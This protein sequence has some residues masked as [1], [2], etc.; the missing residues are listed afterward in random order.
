VAQDIDDDIQF[1]DSFEDPPAPPFPF[2][3]PPDPAAIAP[4]IDTTV[5]GHFGD[6]LMFLCTAPEP[7]Q[8]G[9]DCAN[10]EPHRVAA[11]R[12]RAF[13][14]NGNP[15][16]GVL[17]HIPDHPEFGYTFSRADGYYDLVVNGGGELTLQFSKDDFLT[18]QR[19][20]RVR[21]QQFESVDDVHLV[22]L[23]SAV[24]E[25]LLGQGFMQV[26]QATMSSDADGDRQATM[27]FPIGLQAEIRLADGSTQALSTMNVRATEYTVG[28]NGPARMPATLPEVT[29]YTYA[30]ELS[31]DEAIALA[32]TRVEFDQPIWLYVE[33]FLDFP[34]GIPVPV[35]YYDFQLQSWIPSQDGQIIQIVDESNGF[36]LVDVDGDGAAEDPID[37]QTNLSMTSDEL[38]Q[39]AVL[40]QPGQSLWRSPIMHFTP[41]D[42]NWPYGPGPDD[43]PPPEPTTD[44]DDDNPPPDTEEDDTP[45]DDD[46]PD[47]EDGS[48]PPDDSEPTSEEGGDTEPESTD[49]EN[50]DCMTGSIIECENRV[51][52]ETLRIPG[53]DFN[54]TYRSSRSRGGNMGISQ[55]IVRV[56]IA[57]GSVPASLR[58]ASV[59][60]AVDGTPISRSI[61]ELSPFQIE[62]FNVP[63]ADRFSREYLIRSAKTDV[64]LTYWYE[65]FYYGNR[66]DFE[67]SFGIT[68]GVEFIGRRGGLELG[69]SRRW[70]TS[71]NFRSGV[72]AAQTYLAKSQKLGGWTL[73]E[74]HVFDARGGKLWKGDGGERSVTNLSDIQIHQ[75][76]P[77]GPDLFGQVND[78]DEIRDFDIGPDGSIVVLT[79]GFIQRLLVIDQDNQIIQI[80]RSCQP[81]FVTIPA[82]ARRGDV[83]FCSVGS[84]KEANRGDDPPPPP[85]PE[86]EWSQGWSVAWGDNGQ[87]FL[88]TQRPFGEADIIRFESDGTRPRRFE[89][90]GLESPACFGR[91]NG[92]DFHNRRLFFTC[93]S[94]FD[95]GSAWMLWPNGS[96]SP[97]A[98]AIIEPPGDTLPGAPVSALWFGLAEP[99]DISVSPDGDIYIAETGQHRIRKIDSDGR[100]STIAGTGTAGF[101]GEGS[102]ATDALLSS[103]SAVA[104]LPDGSLYIADTGNGRLRLVDRAGRISTTAGGGANEFVQSGV[105]GAIQLGLLRKIGMHE[106][107]S[108]VLS[109]HSLT[110]LLQVSFNQFT[111][112]PDADVYTIPSANGSELFIFSRQGRHLETRFTLTYG[113]KYSFQYNASGYLTA[114][115]DGDG[116]TTQIQ[117][118]TNNLAESIISPYGV[119]TSLEYNTNEDLSAVVTADSA[120]WEMA[121]QSNTG[122]LVEFRDPRNN[123]SEYNYSLS[124]DLAS[125]I[126]PAGGGWSVSKWLNRS[127]DEFQ[128]I[129][130]NSNGDTAR[131]YVN[132][133]AT[134]REYRRRS[135]PGSKT[136]EVLTPAF[137]KTVLTP[138]RTS[139]YTIM[140]PDPRFGLLAPITDKEIIKTPFGLERKTER[141]RV[142]TAQ[143]SGA[144]LGELDIID[145][146]T[147]NGRIWQQSYNSN[148]LTWTFTSPQGRVS[149]FSL[150]QQQRPIR[151]SA[152][153]L[154]AIDFSY[155]AGGRLARV[156][157]GEGDQQREVLLDYDETG[158]LDLIQ[159]PIGR[160]TTFINDPVGRPVLQT[161]PD[162]EIINLGYD[163]SGNLNALAPP[164]KPEHEFD[165]SVLDQQSLYVPPDIGLDTEQTTYSYDGERRLLN[166]LRPDGLSVALNYRSAD[167]IENIQL[168]HGS[169]AITYHD[170][171]LSSSRPATIT[172]PGGVTLEFG[173][174]G[175]LMTRTTWLG[176]VAGTLIFSFDNDL[177]LASIELASTTG[178]D[179]IN[180]GYDL[181]S[182]LVNAGDLV[183]ARDPENGLLEGTSLD[184]V[185]DTMIYNQFGESIDYQATISGSGLFQ[186]SFL[187]DKL[188]RITRKT[189]TVLGISRVYDYTYDLAGRLE[190]VSVDGTSQSTYVYDANGNR[191]NHISPGNNT[192]GSYDNQDRLLSYGVNTYEYTANGEM[193]SKMTPDG[194]TLYQYDELGNLLSVELPDGDSI[195]YIIDGLNRRIGKK[196]NGVLLQGLLYQDTLNPVAELDGAGNV[197][198]RFVYAS[199]LNVPD[200]MIK[201]SQR[202][203]I[204][205]DQLGSP[206]LVVN[207]QTGAVVQQLDYDEFGNVISDS[208]PGFQPFGFAG[209]IA[210]RDTGLVRFGVRDYDPETGRWTAKDPLGYSNIENENLYLYALGDSINYIDITGTVTWPTD[211]SAITSPF[212]SNEGR[213]APHNGTDIRNPLDG[214]V[215]STHDG[216]IIDINSNSRGG[217]QIIILNTDGS[218]SGYAHTKAHGDLNIGDTVREG[219]SIGFSNGSGQLRGPHLHYTYSTCQ[220]CPRIDPEQILPD[221][222]SCGN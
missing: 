117:R 102:S 76:L 111:F 193:V 90:S 128:V 179:V 201:G 192:S 149:S 199:K 143:Q 148:L 35:G 207:T 212:N 43:E 37:L 221:P 31:A 84:G 62:R 28:P 6:D 36:A 9:A 183:L 190:T 54:L 166:M 147:V 109:I 32:A 195:E 75:L 118:G 40:Y 142:V 171:N 72:P 188:G 189:E 34:V 196:V 97:I 200:Y 127:R 167:L 163:P 107:G 56:P 67:N 125:N 95:S 1:M 220:T 197:I 202:Y 66:E 214:D 185:T 152:P 63:A 177:R 18:A 169:H 119:V 178:G 176:P 12:G 65:P 126:N 194:E 174:D 70:E 114:I 42:K 24:S 145:S 33:N 96:L 151:T 105:A 58:R 101:A 2:F 7:V 85:P 41:W 156:S 124:G 19:G 100:I 93:D 104:A 122:L 92:S 121:Y 115:I 204:I 69:L 219:E 132:T 60:I 51:L 64:T 57:N 210:D 140:G 150:D 13:D 55:A 99:A 205:S 130:T 38:M 74:H 86:D 137:E 168:N 21:W 208:N 80:S 39:L 50:P 116:N 164:G 135:F 165:Y 141:E 191:R 157:Q 110:Q 73:D 16:A 30:V 112:D 218:R 53:T 198:S 138:E 216:T 144:Q 153:G 8:R 160:V 158:F 5:P 106:N 155:D 172:S 88:G 48:N 83:K 217:D 44:D 78:I 146:I 129:M 68:E 29:D 23:D 82:E 161:R 162:G 170:T 98:G 113:L 108:V 11:L 26:H 206:R 120:R 81:P 3:E 180:Y 20:L 77:F 52:G 46:P 154:A 139:I 87:I 89:L 61:P 49:Q 136:S 27:L 184:Q 123:A 215:Y 103:P 94:D 4:P 91:V 134:G 133:T 59:D 209:G 159:D 222:I 203:R 131:H 22:Q 173:Y 187:R 182:L 25:I 47:P 186:Q 79:G 14:G 213:S 15:L 211:H 10:L 17:V 45:G 181:D 175:P 71:L